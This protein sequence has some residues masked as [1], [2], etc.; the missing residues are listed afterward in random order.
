M[1]NRGRQLGAPPGPWLFAAMVISSGVER[2]IQHYHAI[3]DYLS[4]RKSPRRA[5]ATFS[6]EVDDGDM[7]V[8]GTIS[9]PARG[10]HRV[11]EA[12]R[13]W[14]AKTSTRR[15]ANMPTIGISS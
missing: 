5:I 6:G 3:R 7:Q 12:A 4:E 15:H 11:S 2:T 8:T 9:A 14:N 13:R 1:L 10:W